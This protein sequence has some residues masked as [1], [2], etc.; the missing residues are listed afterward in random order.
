MPTRPLSPIHTALAITIAVIAC[1]K[2][3]DTNAAAG[4]C[5]E[6]CALKTH[7]RY[8]TWREVPVNLDIRKAVAD[9]NERKVRCHNALRTVERVLKGHLKR[10]IG[11]EKVDPAA[12]DIAWKYKIF[13]VKDVNL[14]TLP[15]PAPPSSGN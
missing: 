15:M 4:Y 8:R 10:E 14:V 2:V 5:V 12:N 11:K 1:L 13:E 7:S 9:L 6:S 3:V